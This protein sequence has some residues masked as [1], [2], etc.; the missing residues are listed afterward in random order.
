MSVEG[1]YTFMSSGD[2]AWI[3]FGFR[4]EKANAR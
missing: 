3:I 1:K 2:A 4:R